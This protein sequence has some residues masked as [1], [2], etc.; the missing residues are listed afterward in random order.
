MKMIISVF[1]NERRYNKIKEKIKENKKLIILAIMIV[2]I[3]IIDQLIKIVIIKNLYN[4]SITLITGILNLTYVENKGGAF[5][6]GNS[7]T[8]MFIIVSVIVI[9]LITKFII[10]KKNY[11]STHILISL[12]LIVSGGIS[13]LIDRIFRGFVVDYIDVS[14]LIKYP[15]FNIA[16]MFVVIGCIGIAINLVVNIIKERKK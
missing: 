5:G 14:P 6:I 3:I 1:M 12:G 13:N 15:V 8:V 9:T 2:L 4:S 7:S 10:S 16:D 11:I